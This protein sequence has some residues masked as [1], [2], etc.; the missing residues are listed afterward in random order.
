MLGRRSKLQL[1]PAM[2]WG[3][4]LLRRFIRLLAWDGTHLGYYHHLLSVRN[5]R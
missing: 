3:I 5:A 4:I 1:V 2:P